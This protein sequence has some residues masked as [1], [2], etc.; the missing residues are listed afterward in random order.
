MW[1]QL[2]LSVTEKPDQVYIYVLSPFYLNISLP[3]LYVK[4]WNDLS[5]EKYVYLVTI[6][7]G[8]LFSINIEG[9]AVTFS[10]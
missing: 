10:G 2:L 1:R 4:I 9:L 7:V 3:K 6:E 5:P 8:V